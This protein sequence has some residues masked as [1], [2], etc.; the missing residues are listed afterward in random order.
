MNCKI[1]KERKSQKHSQKLMRYDRGRAGPTR[2]SPCDSVP[3]LLYYYFSGLYPPWMI[4][5]FLARIRPDLLINFINQ[6]TKNAMKTKNKSIPFR[7]KL[8]RAVA[9]AATL[10]LTLSS[11][12]AAQ[13]RILFQ[14]DTFHEI[15]SEN[16]LLDSNGTGTEDTSIQFGNSAVPADNGTIKW[17]V[18]T[19]EFQ[20]NNTVDITG[21]LDVSGDLEADGDVDFSAATQTRLREETFGGNFIGLLAPECQNDGELAVDTDTED[22]YICIDNL[23]NEWSLISLDPSSFLSSTTNDNYESGTMTFDTGTTINVEGDADFSNSTQF[24]IRTETSDP[25]TCEEGEMYYNTTTNQA[26]LCTASNTW[27]G[28]DPQ[29]FEEVY[30]QDVDSTLTTSG[31][32]FNIATGVGEF[33]V[34]ST[35]LIDF[36]AGDF[37]V[38]V[39]GDVAV[40]AGGAITFNAGAASNFT[41]TTGAFSIDGANGV[42]IE[43]NGSQIDLTTTGGLVD[44]NAALLDVDTTGGVSINANAASELNVDSGTLSLGTTTAGNVN[45]TAADS[46]VLDDGTL[47]TPVNLNVNET[48]LNSN[49]SENG[50][51]DAL[52]DLQSTTEG[53][54]GA[55]YIA[56]DASDF[57]NV[58]AAGDTVQDFLEAVDVALGTVNSENN[59]V[60]VFH[61]EYPDT[62]VYQDGTSNRGKVESDSDG[63]RNFYQ[64]TTRQ[65]LVQDIDLRFRFVLSSDWVDVGASGFSFDY[66]TGVGGGGRV[67]VQLYN[68]SSDVS[69][70]ISAVNSNAAWTTATVAK[71]SLGNCRV[72]DAN[73]LVAGDTVEFRIKLYDDSGSSDYAR[74]GVISLDYDN[75]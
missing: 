26:L 43:G 51:V 59:D 52:N 40:D 3:E 53:S 1:S 41:T 36:N 45:V 35:G 8:S 46:L 72:G 12:G 62:V 31:G 54:E 25:V 44:V 34:T 27:T 28:I 58:S 47:T 33:D 19:D 42:N 23:A 10:V 21:N 13:A 16:I 2:S 68:V 17:D 30:A 11:I 67:D 57:T 69:C 39:T 32:D 56:T 24:I 65:T 64:W 22:L 18:T 29:D 70:G 63:I 7:K 15:P 38:D 61:P 66:A 5:E 55:T 9:L 37:D 75:Q 4:C 71:G 6:I 74:I 60:L 14:D 20:F 73:P 48:E 50:L 49:Y